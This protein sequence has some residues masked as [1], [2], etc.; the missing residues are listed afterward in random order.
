MKTLADQLL[1]GL[2]LVASIA[3]A[4]F[5]LGPRAWRGRFVAAG[6]RLSALCGAH[7]LAARLKIAS[8]KQDGGGCDAC[9]KTV[10]RR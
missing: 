6:A 7:G 9:R 3:Y 5:A 4:V 1:V 8:A 2:A 10:R